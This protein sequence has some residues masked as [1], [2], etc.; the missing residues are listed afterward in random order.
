[1]FISIT[2]M[3]N[4]LKRGETYGCVCPSANKI[5]ISE[6]SYIHWHINELT[7][8]CGKSRSAYD[9][10]VSFHDGT[11]N[12]CILDNRINSHEIT[13]LKRILLKRTGA[14][15]REFNLCRYISTLQLHVQE[16][17]NYEISPVFHC[18]H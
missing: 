8:R 3:G 16:S 18:I 1:V 2:L 13:H 10:N 4:S 11:L 17:V 9:N 5:F 12:I 14:E 6:S 7:F 15:G